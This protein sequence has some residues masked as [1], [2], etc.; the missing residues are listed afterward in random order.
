MRLEYELVFLQRAPAASKAF[1]VLKEVDG[2]LELAGPAGIHDFSVRIINKNQGTG[3][4][5]RIH[6]PIFQPNES[7][8]VILDV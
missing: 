2:A 7:I 1:P 6:R 5:K 4:D 3:L 8:A